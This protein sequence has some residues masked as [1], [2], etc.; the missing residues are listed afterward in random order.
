LI[1]LTAKEKDMEP[2]KLGKQMLT[3]SKSTFDSTF[4]TIVLFQDQWE[5]L[6]A[7]SLEHANWVPED[8]RKAVLDGI[9]MLKKARETF[10]SA[11]DE[12]FKKIETLFDGQA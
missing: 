7:S 3:L 8:K 6:V 1:P 4:N 12:N 2:Q 11:A 10:K 5:K 9:G